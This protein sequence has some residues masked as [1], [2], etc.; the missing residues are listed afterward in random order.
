MATVTIKRDAGGTVF[1]DPPTIKLGGGDFVVW[2]NE[3]K[4]AS[5]QPTLQGQPADYWMDFPLPSYV[6]GQPAASSPAISFANAAG[7]PP[8]KYVDGLD[9]S[10]AA[11]EITF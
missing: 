8:V 6:D 3:D 7:S 1:F 2:V 11:G 4:E 9:A 5:H 10:V